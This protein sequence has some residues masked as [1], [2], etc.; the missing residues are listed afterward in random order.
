MKPVYLYFAGSLTLTFGLAACIPAAPEPAPPPVSQPMPEPDP[1]PVATP[2]PA[3]TPEYESY[4][5]APQTPGD[6]RYSKQDNGTV[7]AF[8]TTSG[9][10]Q[11]SLVCRNADRMMYLTRWAPLQGD[12][13]MTIR[14]ETVTR[15]IATKTM[16]DGLPGEQATL[17][18]RDPLLDA[19]A[20]TKG[21]FAVETPGMP[22]LYLPAWPEISRVI[23]DCR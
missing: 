21:R 7:A 17:S 1:V 3:P 11:F 18:A 5:D 19:M 13:T 16:Q 4:L 6:W 12:Q 22:T 8:G 9:M 2:A 15:K 10:P 14:T 20:I 23:E